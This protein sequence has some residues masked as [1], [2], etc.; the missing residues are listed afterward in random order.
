MDEIIGECV[1]GVIFEQTTESHEKSDER[2]FLGE[3]NRQCIDPEGRKS[4][5][6]S[7]DSK[8]VRGAKIK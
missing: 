2:T 4:L 5:S 1:F 3:K 8:K 6:C 7:E